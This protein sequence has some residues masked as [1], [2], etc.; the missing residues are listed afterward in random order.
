MSDTRLGQALGQAAE[1]LRDL[2]AVPRA[3]LADGALPIVTGDL[4]LWCGP[5]PTTPGWT[6]AGTDVWYRLAREPGVSYDE[7]V[8]VLAPAASVSA[9]RGTVTR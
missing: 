8:A 9:P 5:Q 2:G 1:S 4:V 7:H 6:T 3:R